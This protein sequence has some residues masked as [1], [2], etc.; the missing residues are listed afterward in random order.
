MSASSCLLH[1]HEFDASV[2]GASLRGVIGRHEV[3]LPKSMRNQP[4]LRNALLSEI[5]DHRVGA[6]LRQPEVVLLAPNRISVPIDVN[7]HIGMR[8][9]RRRGLIQHCR[10]NRTNIVLAQVEMHAAKHNLLLGWRRRRWWRWRRWWWRR[11]RWRR[12]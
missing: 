8:L 3:R 2:L 11:R 6:P 7:V 1:G 9:E 4:A 12:R 5:G 10:V